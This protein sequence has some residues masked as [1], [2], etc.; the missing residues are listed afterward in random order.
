MTITLNWKISESTVKPEA[1]DKKLSPYGVYIRKFIQEVPETE[2][3]PKKYTY[4]EAFL[5][6]EEYSQYELMQIISEQVLGEDSS[7]AYLIYKQQLNT[8]VIYEVNGHY[9][10]PKWA[11][12]I[13][14]ELVNRGEKFAELF[15]LTIWDATEL[16]E[17]AVKMS[18]E[19]LRAL[20]VFLGQL[21]EQ[22]FNEYKIAK[23]SKNEE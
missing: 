9:Y 8:P 23:E 14:E 4:Q 3:S 18:L 2:D 11:A 1:V 21:Q 13:Y 19:E 5:S 10:K 16:Q 6:I 20:T 17:N 22:Y 7:D 12:E 15:P